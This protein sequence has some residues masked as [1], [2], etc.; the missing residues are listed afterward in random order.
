MDVTV[1]L[2]V[3]EADGTSLFRSPKS[4]LDK[5]DRL[6]TRSHLS[7][8]MSVTCYRDLEGSDECNA[9]RDRLTFVWNSMYRRQSRRGKLCS[10]VCRLLSTENAAIHVERIVSAMGIFMVEQSPRLLLNSD[11]LISRRFISDYTASNGTM[12]DE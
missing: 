3:Y 10:S 6:L 9:H 5:L 7:L 4:N 2:L 12:T 1:I 8:L 11:G